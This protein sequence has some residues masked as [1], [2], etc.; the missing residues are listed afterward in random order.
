MFERSSKWKKRK[1]IFSGVN[2]YKNVKI[3]ISTLISSVLS[4]V[5]TR[6]SLISLTLM[7]K[8]NKN[9]FKFLRDC[10]SSKLQRDLYE[11]T[12]STKTRK[13]IGNF[14]VQISEVLKPSETVENEGKNVRYEKNEI[15]RN[16]IY[17][18]HVIRKSKIENSSRLESSSRRFV[19]NRFVVIP[20]KNEYHKPSYLMSLTL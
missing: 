17:A 12:P 14:K 13:T 18:R 20:G 1:L 15:R 6:K 7:N 2:R 19:S 10:V 11:V 8:I 5:S 16:V 4:S 3:N 9:V